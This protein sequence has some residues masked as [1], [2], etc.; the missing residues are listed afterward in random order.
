MFL[1]RRVLIFFG[2]GGGLDSL[3]YHNNSIYWDTAYIG[4]P[5]V[6]EKIIMLMIILIGTY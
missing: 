5:A 1:I 3:D 4:T 2:G 6:L